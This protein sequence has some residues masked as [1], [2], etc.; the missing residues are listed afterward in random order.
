MSQR[1]DFSSDLD[2]GDLGS[3]PSPAQISYMTFESVVVFL[4]LFSHLG[5]EGVEL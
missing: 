1:V 5:N 4:R 3:G 2:S